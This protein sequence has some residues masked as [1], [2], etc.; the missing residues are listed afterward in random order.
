M[1]IVDDCSTDDTSA[2]VERYSASDP[3]IRLFQQTENGGPARARNTALKAAMGR[4]IAFLDSD[5][6]WLPEKLER[7]L[8]FMDEKGAALSYT[9]YR[10]F[11]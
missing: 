11:T 6:L 5:D 7:Q 8:A 3:R 1:L 4:Y 2:V 10:R 9:L